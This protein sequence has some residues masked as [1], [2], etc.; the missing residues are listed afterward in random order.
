MIAAI[1]LA[2]GLGSRM[3]AVKPL[4]NIDGEPALGRA[5][6]GLRGAGLSD[7]I[8]VLGRSAE[9]VRAAVD[10]DR[11]RVVLNDAPEQG[12]STSLALGLDAVPAGALGALVLHADMPFVLPDTITAVV[13]AAAA[14]AG[15]VAP[16]HK[17]QRG[18]PVFFR[19]DAFAEL[20]RSLVGDAGGR[21]YIACHEDELVLVEVDDPGCV[22]DLDRPADLIRL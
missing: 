3:G 22:R 17:G 21:A 11:C 12:M 7:I 9:E 8:V 2:A 1:V 20:R 10:L 5:L 19:R 6:A 13:D 14:G 16:T 4:L 18:F 15:I